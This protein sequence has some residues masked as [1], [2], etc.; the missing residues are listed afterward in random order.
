MW[1]YLQYSELSMLKNAC[2]NA[3]PQRQLRN[4]SLSRIEVARPKDGWTGLWLRP[5]WQLI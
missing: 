3:C 4:F 2:K 1:I 5:C